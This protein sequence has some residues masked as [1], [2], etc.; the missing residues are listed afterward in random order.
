MKSLD[1]RLISKIM[2]NKMLKFVDLKK[3]SPFKRDTEKR[4]QDDIYTLPKANTY[5]VK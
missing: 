1:F 5:H 2:N 3:E 4:R